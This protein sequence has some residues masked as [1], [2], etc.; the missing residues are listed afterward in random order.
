LKNWSR[1]RARARVRHSTLKT[2]IIISSDHHV[3]STVA[4]CPPRIQLDDGGA[5]HQSPGQQWL[6]RGWLDFG[7]WARDLSKGYKPLAL[8]V[9]DLGELDT[10]RRSNQIITANKATIT[11]MINDVVDPIAA[12]VDGL[13]FIR[14]TPAHVGKSSWLEEEIAGDYDNAVHAAKGIHSHYQVR[15]VAD[16]VRVEAAHHA[17]MGSMARTQKNA[18]NQIAFDT[19]TAYAFDLHQPLP[20][21]VFRAHNHRWADSYDNHETRAICLPCW[22]MATEYVYRI[23]KYNA[24]ADVGGVVVLIEDGEYEVHKFRLEPRKGN[25]WA[26]KA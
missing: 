5:Y 8:F 6:W 23:G 22:S 16:R 18:A 15:L 19:M 13:Y 21:L 2:A 7:A 9:G 4:V 12:W 11:G 1:R 20:D 17:S 26:R 14:G 24:S 25:V 3:N 10:K